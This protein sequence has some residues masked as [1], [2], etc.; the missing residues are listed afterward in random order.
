M[1][2]ESIKLGI[3]ALYLNGDR[4]EERDFFAR[5]IREAGRL[6][7]DAYVFTPEDASEAAGRIRAHV[8]DARRR[9]WTRAWRPF[10]DVVFD[11]C[12]YQRTPRFRKLQEFRSKHGSLLYMNRPLANKWAI[13]RLLE[14]DESIRPHLPETA[15]YRG[16]SAL[17]RFLKKH[18]IV[19]V[20]PVNGTGGRGVLRVEPDG[21][22]LYRVRGRDR[23]RRILPPRRTTLVGVG[24]LLEALGLTTDGVMQQGI[25]LTLP[26]GR[27]H[28]YRLLVQKTGAGEWDVTGCAGRIGAARSVTSNLHG[29]G[30]AIEAERLLRTTFPRGS[31]AGDVLADMHALGLNVVK[32]LERHYRD[33]CELALDLAVDRKGNVWLLEINPK[34]ARDVFRRVGDRE[35]YRRAV[36]RPLEYAKWLYDRKKR[37][38]E[39]R[40]ET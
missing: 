33:M 27:V 26:N 37:E 32:R 29:G 22:G 18:G 16:T 13:H 15:M 5:L 25:E 20:K 19:F 23:S 30:E 31:K 21:G 39:G 14:T 2:A 6:G 28:D 7:I 35:A 9:R 38:R 1:M 8:Y 40:D 10:P 11:R 17:H 4:L 36:V 3:M 12:R 24:R 34:P